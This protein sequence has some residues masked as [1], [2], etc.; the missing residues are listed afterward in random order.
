MDRTTATTDR[1]SPRQQNPAG[2]STKNIA[3]LRQVLSSPDLRRVLPGLGLSCF[4]TNILALALPLGILQIVDRVVI[5]QSTETLLFLV[6]GIVLALIMQV[7]LRTA[8]GLITSWL[9]TRFEHKTSVAALERLMHVPLQRYQMEEPGVHAERIL[10]SAKVAD[11]YSGEALLVLFDFPFV[12]VFLWLIHI[13]GG[14]LVTV[15][16]LLLLL[17]ALVIYHY[18]DW[19]HKQ[20]EQRN[21]LDDRRFGFLAE[22]LSGIH[23]VKTMSME[24]LLLRRY[25]RLQ[26]TSSNLG[27]VLNRGNA[28]AANMGTVFSQLMIVSVVSASAWLVINGDMTPGSLAACM[29][30]SVRTLRPLRRGLKLWM[31]YQSFVAAHKRLNEV[32]DMPYED[33]SKKPQMPPVEKGL[34]LRNVTLTYNGGEAL[35][36]NLSLSIRAGESIAIRGGSGSGKTS[37]LSLMSAFL[38]PNSGEILVDGL[39]LSSFADNS[40]HKEIALLPQAGTIVSG[41]I[42]ENLTMFDASLNQEAL[43]LA[44]KLGL[45]KVVAGMKLGYETPLGGGIGE[46][47]PAGVSQ[48]ITIIRGLVRNP[49][50]ILFDEANISLDMRG[51][52]LLCEYLAEQRGKRTLV[53][54]TH[55]PSM[56]SLVDKVYTLDK[57]RLVEGVSEIRSDTVSQLTDSANNQLASPERPKSNEDI[58]LVIRRQFD[59]ESDLSICLLP[60]LTALGWQGQP[61]ELAEAMPHLIRRMELSNLCSTMANIDF[62]PK[63]FSSKLDQLD[64]R[65]LPCLFLPP[66]QPA[67]VVLQYQANGNLLVFDSAQRAEREIKPSSKTGNI[68]LFQKRDILLKTRQVET[69]WVGSLMRRFQSHI[70][71]AFFITVAGT[72]LSLAPPLFVRSIYN[73]V[74]PSGD[75][76]MGISLMGGAILAIM[77]NS[78]LFLTKG[79]VMAFISGRSE[80]ILGNSIFQRIIA[81]PTSSIEGSSVSNQVGRVKNLEGLRNF[82]LGPLSTIAFELPANLVLIIAIG[83]I[84]PWVLVVVVVSAT[85]FIL[86]G[87]FSRKYSE[88]EVAKSSQLAALRWEFLNEALTEM[89]SIRSV[90][91]G[92]SWVGR[93]REMSGKSVMAN[94]HNQKMHARINAIAGVLGYSTG[95]LSLALSAYLAIIGQITSGTMVATMMIIWRLVGPIQNIFQSATSLV[96]TRSNV[97][98]IENLMRLKGESETGVIQTIRPIVQGALSFTRVSFRYANDADPVLLGVSF[99]ASPGQLVVIAGSNGSGKSTLLKLIERI[100]IPQAGTIRL[101]NV[102]IRQLT[103][104]D[105]RAKIS[106]MPQN[107]E[108]FYGTVAQNLRLANPVATDDELQWA[109]EMAGLSEDIKALPDGLK[110][111]ISNSRS[112]QLSHGFRQRLSLARTIVKPADLVLLDEPATGMDQAGEAALMRCI[113]WLRGRSTLI[114]VSHRPSHMRLTDTVIVMD[115]G[116]IVAMGAFDIVKDKIM[117]VIS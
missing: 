105:L 20:V 48:I 28:L 89:V 50:V 111:R 12:V 35:F 5:N 14:M 82:F 24:S 65:L 69:T 70:L 71:V 46:T 114:M 74:L 92:N 4:L 26:E 108:F 93:F 9:G 76:A 38:R 30:L 25:E 16:I 17:F 49:S 64:H 80:Y 90:G 45:G 47:L 10:A 63:H 81:L 83:I 6:I 91:A 78:L 107:C 32:L 85:L 56:Y 109:I 79:R 2:K 33:D 37:L 103:A 88:N 21:I 1:D 43:R 23:S 22:V 51:D 110:T 104:A 58:A 86:L 67:M 39:P 68:Y 31:R 59:E 87:L 73:W 106:Y 40:I 52:Q 97:R 53:M 95:L 96:R 41:N 115:R 60:L 61:R 84:N 112:D 13:L 117:S 77:V 7:I 99:T 62:F 11:F 15:P 42:L 29:M 27:E 8:N 94:F 100:Y 102:D 101:D 57:G 116:S 75:I 44:E 98:Q 3:A 66:D 54:V 36:D 55:R 113:E 18:G 72:M 34:E 19:M